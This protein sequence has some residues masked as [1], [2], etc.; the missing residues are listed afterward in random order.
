MNE[1]KTTNQDLLTIKNLNIS[2]GEK[3]V[4]KD[5]SFTIKKGEVFC[6]VGESGSGKS[7]SALSILKLLPE[8]VKTSTTEFTFLGKDLKLA[9]EKEMCSIRGSEISMIFQE[10]MTSLNPVIRVGEQILEVIKLH[11]KISKKEMQLQCEELFKRV[12]LSPDRINDYPH[13][14]SGGMRQRVM[15]AMALA[16]S[17]KL[18]IADEPTTALD[19]TIQ[20]QILNLLKNLVKEQNMGLL[21][22]THDLGV[23]SEIA[24]S[25][26]VIYA[27]QLMEYAK[28]APFFNKPLHPYSKSL[29]RCMPALMAQE[30]T[31]E[32]SIP[33]S[34]EFTIHSLSNTDENL[35]PFLMRCNEK[36]HTCNTPVLLHELTTPNTENTQ[37]NNTYNQT[38]YSK[39]M[40]NEE[41]HLVRCH[42]VDKK[43]I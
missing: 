15:I 28:V 29:M 31:Q 13:Q 25:V 18:L 14:L 1:K 7:L 17:P 6:I 16:C 35:C 37:D 40:H 41:K 21:L 4:V 8:N 34:T 27:G 42:Q 2:F 5:F 19:V 22:I 39:D 20:G 9:T 26:A 32:K 36:I 12:G 23:V 30:R 3:N 43:P 11:K 10:P 24:D 33:F 38:K